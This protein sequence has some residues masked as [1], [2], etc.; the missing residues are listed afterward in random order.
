MKNV[1]TLVFLFLTGL[2][3][4][5][6]AK[7]AAVDTTWRTN[8]LF[9]LNFS[10]TQ[11]SN[12]AGGGQNNIAINGLVNYQVIYAKGVHRW[13]SKLDAQF[14]IIRT[15]ES[16]I[17]KKNLDQLLFLTKYNVYAFKKY[18]FYTAQ[19]DYRTQFAPGYVYNNDSIVGRATSDI[20]SPGYIQLSLGLDYKPKDYFSVTLAPLAGKITIVNRQYLAD[21]GAYGVQKAEFDTAGNVVKAGQRVRYEFGGKLIVRFKREIIK[22]VTL[23]SYLDLFS[24]Y[25][26][27]PQNIDVVFNNLLNIK[28]NK[29]FSFTILSQMIYDNDIVTLKDNNKNGKFDDPGDINGPRLQMMNTFAFGL[30]YKF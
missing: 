1:Y 20:N 29:Y 17:F 3:F 24:N 26:N 14:G 19:A 22:N 27:N 30:T 5:Q 10:Q 2:V 9:G 15:G 8:G 11:L 18:W 23:D 13:E 4:S 12:W 21:Q 7:P 25:L 28:L 6:D 16:S